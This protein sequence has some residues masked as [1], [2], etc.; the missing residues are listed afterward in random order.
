MNVHTPDLWRDSEPN[1]TLLLRGENSKRE[2]NSIKGNF[3]PKP[4]SL[5]PTLN[6]ITPT[7][8]FIL[9]MSCLRPENKA[10]CQ[11]KTTLMFTW[12]QKEAHYDSCVGFFQ[13]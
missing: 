10:P 7:F 12:I 3:C 13:F 9:L 11:S 5:F 4:R 1:L 6:L 2:N 8:A